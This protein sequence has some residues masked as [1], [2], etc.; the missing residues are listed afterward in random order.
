M[1]KKSFVI[2]L[3][4]LVFTFLATT[5]I[6]HFR[7]PVP[8]DQVLTKVPL[9]KGD[10]SGRLDAVSPP[11]LEL[12]S[13]D[14]YFSASFTNST[15]AKVQVFVDYYSPENTTGA[16]HSPRNCLPGS[17]W[18]I[19]G[20]MPRMIS[21]GS[22]LIKANRFFLTLGD[23]R[24][25]MDFWYITRQGETANDYVLKFNTMISSLTLRPTDK[26]FVRFVTSDN[27]RSLASLEEFEALFIGEIYGQLPF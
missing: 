12:L 18:V 15:G 6:S 2:I 26:A 20:S 8:H 1:E 10:W 7:R 17:G 9:S 22:H 23:S 16:I 24:Q 11:V 13:P 21:V 27:P 14:N 19:A 3:S 25:V 4:A 5:L